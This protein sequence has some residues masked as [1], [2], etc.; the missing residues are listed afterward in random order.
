MAKVLACVLLLL[1]AACSANAQWQRVVVSWT[2]ENG[3]ASR[4]VSPAHDSRGPGDDQESARRLV[5]S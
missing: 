1:C 2:G 4:S 3:L 5:R